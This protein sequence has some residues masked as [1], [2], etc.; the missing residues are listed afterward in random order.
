[1]TGKTAGRRRRAS[2]RLFTERRQPVD[3]CRWR[4]DV[5]GMLGLRTAGFANR[6]LAREPLASGRCPQRQM[7]NIGNTRQLVRHYRQTSVSPLFGELPHQPE[8]HTAAK[9]ARQ[10]G[11]A[12]P[13][14]RATINPHGIQPHPPTIRHNTTY[15]TAA[16]T[17]TPLAANTTILQT[18]TTPADSE[19]TIPPAT[20]QPN[21]PNPTR[22][23]RSPRLPSPASS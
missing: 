5:P 20:R 16:V 21:P 17:P 6:T 19:T 23:R 1:M 12:E 4:C 10:R 15:Q 3:S 14:P 11:I 7:L 18:H 13:Q 8:R 9:T 2:S 22:T